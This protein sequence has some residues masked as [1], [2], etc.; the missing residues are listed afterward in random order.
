MTELVLGI[1]LFV[2]RLRPLPVREE[3]EEEVSVLAVAKPAAATVVG[4]AMKVVEVVEEDLVSLGTTIGCCLKTLTGAAGNDFAVDW[5]RL[6]RRGVL[7]PPTPAT[8]AAALLTTRAWA[9][10]HSNTARQHRC[11]GGQGGEERR[12]A[13]TGS[14]GEHREAG[15]SGG[16]TRAHHKRST[17]HPHPHPHSRCASTAQERSEGNSVQRG[18]P[19]SPTPGEGEGLGQVLASLQ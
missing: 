8:T 17:P 16:E 10:H 15:M 18:P 4:V 5:T 13:C 1:E 9:A 12:C 7:L 19:S 6:G 2:E 3:E 11:R 14:G